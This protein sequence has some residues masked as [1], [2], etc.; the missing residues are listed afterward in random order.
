MFSFGFS[1]L[2]KLAKISNKNEELVKEMHEIFFSEGNMDIETGYKIDAILKGEMK[3]MDEEE[4]ILLEI[5]IYD[6]LRKS[7]NLQNR[8]PEELIY[9]KLE[10]IKNK[11]Y[12]KILYFMLEN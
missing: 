4:K 8:P 11:P 1:Y 9:N 10:V 2:T 3:N 5:K 7:D 6:F 12:Q